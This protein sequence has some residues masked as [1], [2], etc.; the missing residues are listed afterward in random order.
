MKKLLTGL[1]PTCIAGSKQHFGNPNSEANTCI[2]I[3]PWSSPVPV[4]N[5]NAS[6]NVGLVTLWYKDITETINVWW[7][8]WLCL[9]EYYHK[10]IWYKQTFSC[11]VLCGCN[12]NQFFHCFVVLQDLLRR[13]DLSKNWFGRRLKGS[14]MFLSISRKGVLPG[15]FSCSNSQS[16]FP[17]HG[18]SPQSGV[19]FQQ[20]LLKTQ[21]HIDQHLKFRK[22]W[23][24]FCRNF[25]SYIRKSSELAV[26]SRL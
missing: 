5:H 24:E 21:N 3:Y 10:G 2:G 26:I 16:N 11:Q 4:L 17:A 23:E 22:A 25:L 6:N 19:F 8:T 12:K 18:L 14:A 7:K 9:D 15:W 13:K 1:H 20:L